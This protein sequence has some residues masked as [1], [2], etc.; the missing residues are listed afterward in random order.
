MVFNGDNTTKAGMQA[1][2]A[3]M[4]ERRTPARVVKRHGT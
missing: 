1:E 3:Q 4:L 2:A